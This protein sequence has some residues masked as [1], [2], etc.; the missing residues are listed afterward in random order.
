[1]TII[2]IMMWWPKKLLPHPNTP[3][4]LTIMWS[5]QQ[6]F[7]IKKIPMLGIGMTVITNKPIR[8]LSL[9]AGV[10][11]TTIFYMMLHGEIERPDHILFSDTG[12]EP[13]AVYEHVNE[14]KTIAAKEKIPFHVVSKGNIKEDFV[15][16][17]KTF[18]PLYLKTD[19]KRPGMVRRQCTDRY[20][21][22]PL[23]KKTREL[24]GLKPRQRSKE[25][26]ATT[27]IGISWDESQRMRD[28]AFNWIVNEYPLIDK[29]MTRGDCIA[30]CEKNGY[31]RPP[32]SACIGCPFKKDPEWLELRKNPKE[33]Q[34]AVDFDRALRSELKP[35]QLKYEAFLHHSATPLGEVI[36][37]EKDDQPSLFNQECLGMCGV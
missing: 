22:K 5:N 14:L 12:W 3:L 36:L 30:W 26:L 15:L 33:W 24:V 6:S 1:M 17:N 23:L 31:K 28:P 2:M 37:K 25:I 19:K 35:R 9:G 7:M 32:R 29:K 18:M 8:I 21:L 10:Q 11:S 34:D 27:I 4:C 13:A 20:K 16:T